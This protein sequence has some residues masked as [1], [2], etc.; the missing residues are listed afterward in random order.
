[1]TIEA[2]QADLEALRDTIDQEKPLQDIR[3]ATL[4]ILTRHRLFTDEMLKATGDFEPMQLQAE[5]DRKHTE[6]MEANKDE[7][8]R[9]AQEKGVKE[10]GKYLRESVPPL[11]EEIRFRAT[12]PLAQLLKHAAHRIGHTSVRDRNEEAAKHWESE[13]AGDA[14]DIL[15]Q[16]EQIPPSEKTME[17]IMEH[18]ASAEPGNDTT[19]GEIVGSDEAFEKNRMR[20]LR[21]DGQELDLYLIVLDK[22]LKLGDAFS[23][24]DLLND[25]ESV[26][27]PS[28]K[29]DSEPDPE[30]DALIETLE[31][32]TGTSFRTQE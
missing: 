16:E 8:R 29:H 22:R 2:I 31:S 3:I 14:S 5:R 28:E 9:I 27:Y 24:L 32:L 10:L 25:R 21:E 11:P 20:V 12:Q 6:F 4:R 18:M 1:M 19:F 30:R 17:F 23:G 15:Q 13:V 26:P 7:L